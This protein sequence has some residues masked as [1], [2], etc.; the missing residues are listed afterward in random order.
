M[1]HPVLTAI[2]RASFTPLGWFAPAPDDRVPDSA[3]F[4][5]LIGNAGPDMFRRFA[6]ERDPDRETLD[7]WTRDVV[8]RLAF[9]VG[10]RAVYPFDT[11]PQPF[12]TW[13]RRGGAGHVSPL[14]L[15]IHPTYGLWHA[16]RAALLFT[17]AFDL[18]PPSPGRHPCESCAGRPCLTACPVTAFDGTAYDVE[19]CRSHIA[20]PQGAQ[21]MSQGCLARHACPVG[22]GFAYRQDQASFHMKAFLAA[23]QRKG[24]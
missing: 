3:R 9:D 4:V 24:T 17:V 2:R 18:P 16:Y 12:L 8:S 23:G 1:D 19:A 14:G 11:P 5:I 21:C 7:D 15:N 20:M 13:A 10:A 22:Q 6:R